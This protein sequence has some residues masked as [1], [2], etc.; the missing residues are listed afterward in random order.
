M[1]FATSREL[2]S[3]GDDERLTMAPERLARDR[4]PWERL[5]LL[6]ELHLDC[7][8]ELARVG[9]QQDVGVLVVLGL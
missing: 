8:D 5:E 2:G 1:V 9:G 4:V 3:T 7:L 6:P